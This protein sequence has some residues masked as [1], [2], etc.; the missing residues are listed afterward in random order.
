VRLAAQGTHM[1]D[2]LTSEQRERM[3]AIARVIVAD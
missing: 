3:L 1:H 2:L